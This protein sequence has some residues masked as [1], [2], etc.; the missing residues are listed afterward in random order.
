M[1][2]KIHN[3]TYHGEPISFKTI[4]V[5]DSMIAEIMAREGYAYLPR[6][7]G[8]SVE[9]I[10][11]DAIEEALGLQET[12]DVTTSINLTLRDLCLLTGLIDNNYT[13]D[14]ERYGIMDCKRKLCDGI[15]KIDNEMDE[16]ENN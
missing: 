3:F 2:S 12:M 14:F 10:G 11:D 7:D 1:K 13:E 4:V 6:R 8:D 5:T 9:F 15:I 16:K